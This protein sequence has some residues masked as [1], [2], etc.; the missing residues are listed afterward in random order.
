MSLEVDEA[1]FHH[2]YNCGSV[3]AYGTLSNDPDFI[4]TIDEMISSLQTLTVILKEAN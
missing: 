3:K 2:S 1:L 4:K